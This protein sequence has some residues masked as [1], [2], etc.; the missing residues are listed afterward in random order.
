MGAAAVGEAMA[1]GGVEVGGGGAWGGGVNLNRREWVGW[2][3]VSGE[4]MNEKL[5]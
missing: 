1:G 4:R 3:F 2:G 5:V